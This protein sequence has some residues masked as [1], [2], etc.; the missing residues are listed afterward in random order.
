M[1]AEEAEQLEQ[2]GQL[3][4]EYEIDCAELGIVDGKVRVPPGKII[5]TVSGKRSVR[6]KYSSNRFARSVVMS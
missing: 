4:E 3:Q 1:E 5:G 6:L 2:L